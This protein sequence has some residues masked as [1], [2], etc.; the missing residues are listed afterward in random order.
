MTEGGRFTLRGRLVVGHELVEG[1]LVIERGRIAEVRRGRPGEPV[2][3]VYEAPIVAPG[4][5][6]LQV[7]G[8]FGV[9]VDGNPASFRTLAR[10]LPERGVTAYL[11]TA[12][13]APPEFYSP[14]F[15][16][17]EAALGAPGAEPLGIHLEGPYLSPLRKGAHRLEVIE[18]ARPE[19]LEAL[20]TPHV[21][22]VTLAPERDGAAAM[23]RRIVRHGA[24][25]SLGH[26]NATYEEFVRGVDA[27]ATMATHLYNAMRPFGHR[28]PGPIA[29]TLIDER[30][31][32]GLIAD[33]YHVHPAA[34]RLAVRAR[35]PA[36]V[37]LVSD[38]VLPAGLPSGQYT[39]SGLDVT[40]EGNRTSLPDGTIAGAIATLDE[41]VRNVV[42]WTG[43]S[44]AAAIAMATET[45]A[46]LLGL[47]HK[48][49]IVEGADADLLLLDDGLHV[50][51][52]FARGEC[53]YTAPGFA[54]LP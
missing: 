50:R 44:P 19:G 51:A 52:T 46:R 17:Y 47:R 48:G 3:A 20:L 43:L 25:V 13:T 5:I 42:T 24:I 37:A 1:A 33:G 7:N 4:Y 29:A 38:I 18:A 36:G 15:A 12:I 11:P 34:V 26:L 41:G 27:G 49:R 6:D 22:L 16:A 8:G 45:P 21:R 10:R 23:I 30:V 40:V 28:D 35:G 53:V 32:A 2:G 9:E 54:A 31:T 39:Y 14:V